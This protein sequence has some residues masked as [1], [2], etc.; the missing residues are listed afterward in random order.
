V[1]DLMQYF[2]GAVACVLNLSS[3]VTVMKDFNCR[4]HYETKHASTE[5]R[6]KRHYLTCGPKTL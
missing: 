3:A 1:D 5:R 2:S 6:S 4:R